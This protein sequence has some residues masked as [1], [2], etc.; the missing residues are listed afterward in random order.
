VLQVLYHGATKHNLVSL[1]LTLGW[2][3]CFL[4]RFGDGYILL[5]FSAGFFVAIS[6]HIKEV[7][8]ELFQAKNH[9]DSLND[10]AICNRLGKVASCGDNQW[11]FR[12]Q[13]LRLACVAWWRTWHSNLQETSNVSQKPQV[14]MRHDITLVSYRVKVYTMSNMQETS[15]IAQKHDITLIFVYEDTQHVQLAG[16]IKYSSCLK[17]GQGIALIS[18]GVKIHNMSNLKG[19]SIVTWKP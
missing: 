1:I 16:G 6:T 17:W 8:Q 12:P 13:W 18:C 7:G 10:I 5:G 4:Y 19:T 9:R 3:N 11:V 14:R 15:C 2:L